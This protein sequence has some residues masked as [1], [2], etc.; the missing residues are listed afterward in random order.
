MSFYFHSLCFFVRIFT[1]T[2]VGHLPSVPPYPGFPR[3][4]EKRDPR[5]ESGVTQGGVPKVEE[6][7]GESEC[8][9]PPFYFQFQFLV[10][11]GSGTTS[12]NKR[13]GTFNSTTEGPSESSR[14][15]VQLCS[16]PRGY[17]LPFR[18]PPRSDSVGP[19]QNSCSPSDW[20]LEG[21]DVHL[22]SRLGNGNNYQFVL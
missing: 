11:E 21:L 5:D 15:E 22:L 16:G 10:F 3:S 7:V 19:H 1:V 14:D 6:C 8:T 9:I 2:G 20:G 17:L 12:S 18:V 13:H 4:F